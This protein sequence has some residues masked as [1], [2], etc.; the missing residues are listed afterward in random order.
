MD[1]FLQLAVQ[2]QQDLLGL[3]PVAAVQQEIQTKPFYQYRYLVK[4]Q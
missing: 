1:M 2:Q 4:E 3:S